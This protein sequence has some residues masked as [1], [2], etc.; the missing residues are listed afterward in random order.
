MTDYYDLDYLS[1]SRLDVIRCLR[2][3]LSL[4]KGT[5]EAFE[6]GKQFH[7][8]VLEPDKYETNL[9]VNPKYEEFKFKI[10]AMKRAAL[11]NSILSSALNDPL[12]VRE[13]E[14]FFEEERYGLKCKAKLDLRLNKV[15]YDLKTTSCYDLESFKRSVTEYRY[16]R[17]APFYMDHTAGSHIGIQC[18]TFIFI[19]VTKRSPH[20]TFTVMYGIGDPEICEGRKEYEQ[21]IDDFIIMNGEKKINFKELMNG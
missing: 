19:G 8:A 3:G 14:V 21:L 20:K 5:E 4:S 17:Q 12:S 1:N 2:D 6:F 15:I 10:A 11:E 7:E 18:N 16:T 9:K 13:E